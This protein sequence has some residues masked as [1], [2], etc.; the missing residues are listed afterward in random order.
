MFNT[1]QRDGWHALMDLTDTVPAGWSLVGGQM[2]HLWCAQRDSWPM[3]PTDDVDAV[4]DVRGYPEILASVTGAL[5]RLGFT[6]DGTSASGHQH[7][8]VRER[9]VVDVLIP[10]HLGERASKRTGVGGATTIETP[11]AQKVLNRSGPVLVEVAGRECEI[12]RPTLLGALGAKA[13][14]RTVSLDRGTDR[15]LIDFAVLCTLLR[16]VDLRVGPPLDRLERSRMLSMIGDMKAHR[17]VWLN[18]DGAEAGLERLE[19]GLERM[20]QLRVA[21]RTRARAQTTGA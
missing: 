2:V 21:A 18:V 9:A 7:R 6:P 3:R 17:V 13:S 20:E 19:M 4:L 15:H 10:R 11:G 12:L 8:W 5:A 14:A 16:P 1:A